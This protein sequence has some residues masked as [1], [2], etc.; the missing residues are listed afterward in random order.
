MSYHPD[1]EL[2]LV[3]FTQQDEVPKYEKGGFW[4]ELFKS[5]ERKEKWEHH[6][7]VKNR[8]AVYLSEAKSAIGQ[9]KNNGYDPIYSM[10]QKG[11][12]TILGIKGGKG[13]WKRLSTDRV[14][15]GP[16]IE[17]IKGAVNNFIGKKNNTKEV[18]SW[19]EVEKLAKAE[20]KP[21]RQNNRQNNRQGNRNRNNYRRDQD[22]SNQREQEAEKLVEES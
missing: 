18:K 19:R 17:R 2:C 6:M 5:P 8:N 22:S 7:E 21:N 9:A 16:Y 14:Q 15:N 13:A 3:V 10:I 1:H 20:K 4:E 12:Y 11:E